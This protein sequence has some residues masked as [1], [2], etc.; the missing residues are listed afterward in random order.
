MLTREV[1]V[2][3][4]T[5]GAWLHAQLV[6]L[7][8][9]CW[10]AGCGGQS[11]SSD[12]DAATGASSGSGS[13]SVGGSNAMSTGGKAQS[14]STQTP[15]G[16]ATGGKAHGGSAGRG[17]GGTQT[18]GGVATGGREPISEGGA[19]S[20]G[21]AGGTGPHP[22]DNLVCNEDGT[23][24]LVAGW[25]TAPVL[26]YV[27][28]RSRIEFQPDLGPVMVMQEVGTPCAGAS[29]AD[30]CQVAVAAIKPDTTFDQSGSPRVEYHFLY[31]AGDRV[32]TIGTLYEL[33]AVLGPIDTGN[34]AAAILW[35]LRRPIQ[36]DELVEDQEGYSARSTKQLN[37]CP[38]TYQPVRVRVAH[39]GT[40]SETEV[41][42]QVVTGWCAGRRPPGFV[43][44]AGASGASES[45]AG[46]C[47]A[48]LAEL[49]LASVEAFAWLEQELKGH[50]APLA[51]QER[52]RSARADE[53]RH[54]RVMAQLARGY[55]AAP[56]VVSAERPGQRSLLQLALEN[57]R[58]GAVRELYGATV[59]AWQAQ[60]AR[61]LRVREAF[62]A[63][64]EDEAEHA[65]LAFDI[66]AWFATEL[67]ASERAEVA[68]EKRRSWRQLRE[69]LSS[70]QPAE[71]E[72]QLGF[73]APE[74]ALALLDALERTPLA[75]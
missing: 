13:Q 51:L 27:S 38:S 52:C 74:Q 61:D 43:A 24:S 32:D 8:G 14:G 15:G 39:D 75:A 56:G 22:V 72:Q 59:A 60:H 62:A 9:A 33:K 35:A 12:D 10:A 23:P 29:P 3:R 58:E 1:R 4:R 67:D 2:V 54:A 45:A 69:Q 73:P 41:G 47:L 5:S 6:T 66:D 20:E 71:V 28:L 68:A 7:V 30:D 26:D 21:G 49:E 36:C 63:I 31:T 37:D 34:E 25:R 57:A 64:A 65:A 44:G 55:G 17:G 46:G 18:S 11:I 50:G 16:T 42:Q 53:L 40:V 48:R 19:A 70:A